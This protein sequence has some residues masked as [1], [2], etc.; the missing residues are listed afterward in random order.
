MTFLEILKVVAAV[1]IIATGAFALL[2]PR[3]ITGFIGLEA[4]AGRGVTELRSIFG[5]AFIGLGVYPLV[6]DAAVAYRMLGVIYL[7]IAAARAPAIAI[8]RSPTQS[9]LISLVVEIVLGIILVW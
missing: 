7:A 2:R 9:N 1:L 8:D 3:S 4:P 6:A 5:G